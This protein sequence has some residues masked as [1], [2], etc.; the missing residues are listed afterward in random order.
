M[1]EGIQE[2]HKT[3]K[4]HRDIKPDNIR[5]HGGRI[6]ITDFGTNLNFKDA[7]GNFSLV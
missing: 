2:I 7:N 1:I 5:V 4:I 3:G 6:Y